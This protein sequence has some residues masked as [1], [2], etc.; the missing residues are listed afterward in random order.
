MRAPVPLVTYRLPLSHS[1]TLLLRSIFAPNAAQRVTNF[2]KR[3]VVLYTSDKQA[4][5]VEK[6]ILIE[7]EEFLR[8]LPNLSRIT[9]TAQRG[10][11]MAPAAINCLTFRN[12]GRAL[13]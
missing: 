8:N 1:P 7:Q 5:D 12:L 4:A 9:T 10:L 13:R 6:E 2:A 11:P 3:H